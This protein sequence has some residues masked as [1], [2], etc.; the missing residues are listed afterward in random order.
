MPP[1]RPAGS[2]R[3]SGDRVGELCLLERAQDVRAD[4]V[5]DNLCNVRGRTVVEFEEADIADRVGLGRIPVLDERLDLFEVGLRGLDVDGVVARGVGHAELVLGQ[6]LA[7]IPRV[8]EL[9][10]LVGDDLSR[11]LLEPERLREDI[12]RV[13]S[14]HLADLA[15]DV[16]EAACR[17]GHEDRVEPGQGEEVDAAVLGLLVEVEAAWLLSAR[18]DQ[19]VTTSWPGDDH[20]GEQRREEVRHDVAILVLERDDFEPRRGGLVDLLEVFDQR[21]DDLEI[22]GVRG[23]DDHRVQPGDRDGRNGAAGAITPCS[24]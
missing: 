24:A 3:R 18:L 21:E 15:E 1:V 2:A 17:R 10:E 13:R 23:A 20:A 4:C 8:P 14:V 16:R 9:L 22:P 5:A 7:G 19:E 11:R 6:L 12:R